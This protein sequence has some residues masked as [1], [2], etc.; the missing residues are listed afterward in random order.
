[1]KNRISA[2]ADSTVID[3]TQHLQLAVVQSSGAAKTLRP[4]AGTVI[5]LRTAL[6]VPVAIEAPTQSGILPGVRRG[7]GR[8]LDFLKRVLARIDLSDFPGSCCG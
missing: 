2:A 4:P 1:M 5:P 8:T 7:F 6:P 3:R